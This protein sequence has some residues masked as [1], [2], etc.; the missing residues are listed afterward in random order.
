MTSPT[1]EHALVLGAGIA[2]L[3]AARAVA[4]A[5][6]RVTVVDRDDLPDRPTPRRGVPQGPHAHALLARGRQVLEDLFPGLTADLVADGAPAGD[7]LGDVRLHFDGH[8]LR[9]THSG[10]TVVSVSRALLEHHVRRRVRA[11][12]GVTFAPPSD[13]VGLSATPDARRI[14]GARIL[15]RADGSAEEILDADVVIDATGRGSRTP[16]WLAALGYWRPPE[17]RTPI[18]LG[19]ATCRY[20]LAP[21]AL[22]GDLA[23]L[24]GQGPSHPRGGVLARLEGGE[25][26]LTLSGLTDDRPPARIDA[27]A[28]FARSL[29]DVHAAIRGREPIDDPVIYRFPTSR[30]RRYERL[31]RFPEGLIVLG[32]G[33]CS[34]NPVYGQGMTIAALQ[35]LVLRDHLRRRRRSG[36]GHLRASL[37]RTTRTAWSMAVA[38]DLAL[39][40]VPG[41]RA[42]AV[43]AA[44]AYL[45]Q[46][47]SAGA[48]DTAV[49]TAAVRV[50][51]LVDPPTALLRPRVAA[52]VLRHRG[53]V[54][55]GADA[56]D[57]V[58][59][60][61]HDGRPERAR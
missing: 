53:R 8:R 27:F 4:E 3:L 7:A 55:V 17:D 18:D 30:W 15:R 54:A 41:E 20:R 13:I 43:R 48:Q 61:R 58:G 40:G 9:H 51:G 5:Y 19:Y 37:A 12:P 36:T 39:P 42:T 38:A 29:P 25:W 44:A 24:Y 10:L 49:A 57:R 33:V 26:L 32:D 46:V 60:D 11:L 23:T 21:D 31:T 56:P 14:A 22:G 1:R 50:F 28:E 16:R 34:F 6:D 52:R 35:A 45:D 47:L 2:G 59:A